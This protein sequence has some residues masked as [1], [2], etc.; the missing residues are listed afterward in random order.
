[1]KTTGLIFS[2]LHK[3]EGETGGGTWTLLCFGDLGRHR[4]CFITWSRSYWMEFQHFF[5][6]ETPSIYATTGLKP[7]VQ[8]HNVTSL[9][10]II[11]IMAF[12]L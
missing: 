10:D 4:A 2:S 6:R 7:H 12:F 3:T 1:M 9:D 8:N 11:I 5:Y